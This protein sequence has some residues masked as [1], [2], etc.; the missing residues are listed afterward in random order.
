MTREEFIKKIESIK[1]ENLVY[2]DELGIANNITTLYGWSLKGER[3]YAEQLGFASDR[4]NIVAG[5]N[6]GSKEIGR[7]HV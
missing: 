1:P 3:S 7:A 6:L 2:V 4:R 5:Y